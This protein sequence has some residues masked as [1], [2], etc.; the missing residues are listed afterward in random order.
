[1]AAQALIPVI[2]RFRVKMVCPRQD[3]HWKEYT[4]KAWATVLLALRHDAVA[5][6]ENNPLSPC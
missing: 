3:A 1:M 2:D 4:P 5:M 6:Q